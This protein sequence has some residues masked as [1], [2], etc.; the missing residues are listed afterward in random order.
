MQV[1]GIHVETLE[2][3]SRYSAAQIELACALAQML[4]RGKLVLL[5][6]PEH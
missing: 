4:N 3:P 5:E 1:P 2:D 6:P